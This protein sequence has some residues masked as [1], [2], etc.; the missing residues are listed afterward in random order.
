MRHV[1]L[2]SQGA[3]AYLIRELTSLVHARGFAPFVSA[4]LLEP[5]PEHFPDPWRGD[6]LGVA[7]LARRLLT[8]AG[9]P[10]LKVEVELFESEVEIEKVGT[11]GRASSW[12]HRGAAAWFAGIDHGRCLFGADARKLATPDVLVG[13]MA[14]EVAHAFRHQHELALSK[15]E[16]E[17]PLTDLTTIY[18]GFGV[19]TTNGSYRYRQGGELMGAYTRTEWSHQSLGY[20][21]PQAMSFLLAVQ[22]VARGSSPGECRR[23]AGMLEANQAS[24][25]KTACKGLDRAALLEQM[26]LP[27]P[28]EWPPAAVPRPLPF[29][30]TGDPPPPDP[31]K[32][33]VVA[34][35]G[36]N[37]GLAV[38]RV[39]ETS[40]PLFTAIGIALG[41]IPTVLLAWLVSGWLAAAVFTGVV[42][43]TRTVGKGRHRDRCSEP[44]CS[45]LLPPD[46]ERCAGCG[47]KISGRIAHQNERLDA[48]ERLEGGA[49]DGESDGESDDAQ[50]PDQPDE[51]KA[52]TSL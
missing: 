41:I 39:A 4:P 20:L 5:R 13:V 37:E 48:R 46:A 11:D 29:D 36:R 23:I 38:F 49:P 35:R 34:L 7:R 27:P 52:S 24:Y 12:S 44:D 26:K 51:A 50:E 15:R 42:V 8:Y 6:E 28:S 16:V 32:Q 19:L 1:G 25:F 18:L 43:A 14:H 17:E 40:A 2:L 30:T 47:G 22:A 3:Q 33:E 21:T 45:A 9:L 31:I 10:D